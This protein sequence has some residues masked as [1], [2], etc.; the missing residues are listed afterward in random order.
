MARATLPK[1]TAPSKFS[2]TGQVVT[3]TAANVADKNQFVASGDDLLIIQNSGASAY[4]VTLSSVADPRTGRTGDVTALS[5]PAGQ[6]RVFRLGA[7]GWKQGDGYIY[8]EAN[9]ASILFGVV[10]LQ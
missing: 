9:N 4:T 1:V 5:I 8:L 6:I 3:M 7:L 2:V 10:S